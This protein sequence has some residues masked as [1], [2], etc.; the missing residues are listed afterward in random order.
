M[1]ST[2]SYASSS[3]GPEASTAPR[4]PSP[5]SC[6]PVDPSPSTYP[7][8]G[9]RSAQNDPHSCREGRKQRSE[10]ADPCLDCW[11]QS[12]RRETADAL[13]GEG[14]GNPDA[15]GPHPQHAGR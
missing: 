8:N 4:Q 13:S 6:S 15:V 10:E 3:A 14:G 1:D 11:V 5:W 7:T 2:T 12:G 9:S